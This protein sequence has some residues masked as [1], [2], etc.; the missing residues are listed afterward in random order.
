[1][2]RSFILLLYKKKTP[3]TTTTRCVDKIL[4]ESDFFCGKYY[5]LQINHSSRVRYTFKP[6]SF[7][8][9]SSRKYIFLNN[10]LQQFEV[11]NWK[12]LKIMLNLTS[13]PKW[14][15]TLINNTLSQILIHAFTS[16][17]NLFYQHD[18]QKSDLPFGTHDVAIFNLVFRKPAASIFEFGI[19]P[20]VQ[21][22]AIYFI[23]TMLK[24]QIFLLAHTM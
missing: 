11:V 24:S 4:D 21:A 5:S 17:S 18:A 12:L 13:A 15:H 16:C 8:Q 2:I 22:A 20:F 1:M 19:S 9:A 6:N 23:S 10:L 7:S 3:I 14:Q